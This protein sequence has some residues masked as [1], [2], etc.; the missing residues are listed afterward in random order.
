MKSHELIY[1]LLHPVD[2]H[3]RVPMD[4]SFTMVYGPLE[5]LQQRRMHLEITPEQVNRTNGER[6]SIQ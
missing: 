6:D 3:C 4:P 1:N 2:H 5:L